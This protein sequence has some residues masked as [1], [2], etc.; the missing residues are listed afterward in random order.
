MDRERVKEIL[1]SKGVIEVS[2]KND[3]VWLEAISTDR[4]GK[5]Q[6]KSLSTNKHFNVDIKDLKE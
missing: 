1:A 5:M 6:V 2:Y 3:P 4:D